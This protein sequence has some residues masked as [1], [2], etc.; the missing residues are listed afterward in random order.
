M[1]SFVKQICTLIDAVRYG[2]AEDNDA[3]DDARSNLC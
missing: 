3:K 2:K 1:L